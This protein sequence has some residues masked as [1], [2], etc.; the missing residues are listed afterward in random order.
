MWFIAWWR[1]KKT[2]CIKRRT[3]IAQC[4]KSKHWSRTKATRS[5]FYIPKDDWL[6]RAANSHQ[7]IVL[8]FES[9]CLTKSVFVHGWLFLSVW[10]VV[11]LTYCVDGRDIWW[12]HV[13]ACTAKAKE[14]AR[15]WAQLNERVNKHG[16]L[17][18]SVRNFVYKSK[19]TYFI[20]FSYHP[21]QYSAKG[22]V[23][24]LKM[25]YDK[26]TFHWLRQALRLNS[27]HFQ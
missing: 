10:W 7:H 15:L 21:R 5:L 16:K 26:R 24:V 12:T 2:L 14:L 4:N 9:S 11:V 20:L 8:Q 6:L 3:V 18:W 13:E 27:C 23:S 1:K 17:W 25:E 22:E 19:F